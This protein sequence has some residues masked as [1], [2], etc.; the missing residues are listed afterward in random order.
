MSVVRLM[1]K[2]YIILRN[3]LDGRYRVF[4]NTPSTTPYDMC[5]CGGD[6]IEEAL[7]SAEAWFDIS[8]SEVEL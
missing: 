5:Y 6:T 1:S 8:P 3:P 4:D 7:E 2:P